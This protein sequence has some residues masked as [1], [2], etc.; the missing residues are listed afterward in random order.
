VIAGLLLA[1]LS[2]SEAAETPEPA[3]PPGPGDAPSPVADD[4]PPSPVDDA[5]PRRMS[6]V[7]FSPPGV[8]GPKG[9]GFD[10]RRRGH[11]GVGVVTGLWT[12]GVSVKS[13]V[14]RRDALQATFGASWTPFAYWPGLGAGLGLDWLHQAPVL[15]D[16]PALRLAWNLGLGLDVRLATGGTSLDVGVGVHAVGG[17]ELLFTRLPIDLVFEYRPGVIANPRKGG[18][19]AFTYGDL[20]IHTRWW[21]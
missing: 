16:S 8:P 9:L 18:G 7:E 10:F 15:W 6:A 20:S 4:A 5:P 17:L 3:S 2:L 1:A 14:S 13:M 19:L 21:F 11:T 12:N